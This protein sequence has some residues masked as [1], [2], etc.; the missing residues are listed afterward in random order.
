MIRVGKI[1]RRCAV[2]RSAQSPQCW[3]MISGITLRYVWS[4]VRSVPYRLT[5]VWVSG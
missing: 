2:V 5:A 4:L 1:L 3:R